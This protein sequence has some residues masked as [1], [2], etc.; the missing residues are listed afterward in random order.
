MSLLH[1]L[2]REEVW[3]D[4]FAYRKDHEQLNRREISELTSFL[5]ER[6]YEHLRDLS[7]S[8]PVKKLISKTRSTK[9]RI[10]YSYMPDEMWVLKLLAYLLYR[11][12]EKLPDSCYAF[13]RKRTVRDALEEIRKIEDLDEKVV[14]KA[15]IHD[16][17]NSIDTAILYEI[18]R[19]VIDDDPELLSF[20]RELLDQDRCIYEGEVITEKRGA[21]A[22]VPLA[23]FFANVYL[24]SL[25]RFF[26]EKGI[27]YFR[28]SDDILFFAKDREEADRY[29]EIL[30]EKIGEKKLTI[31]PEKVTVSGPHE[32]FEFLGIRYEQG[33]YDLS[34]VTVQKMKDRIRRKARSIYR[35]RK[36]NGTT[37]EKAAASLIRSMDH[38][39][40]DLFGEN[41]FT[42]TRWYFPVL[43]STNGLHEIDRT[44]VQYLR[45]LK[46]GRHYKGNYQVSYE[47][48]KKLGYTSLVHEFYTWKKE[49]VKL[50]EQYE[51]QC[52]G[53]G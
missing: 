41:A 39:F 45:F 38:K 32:P 26:E 23:S 46:T 21:M 47:E 24:M 37:Y 49:N 51:K 42:W 14:V 31:N 48:L 15:D 27:P 18:L 44:M 11:Y 35:K 50:R 40:Y 4:F 28:Y 20:L 1:D 10:V 8:Y 19:E 25:D 2:Q 36:R 34:H 6:R 13:R 5:A 30:L 43:T 3:N 12:E 33:Q 52:R 29:Y 16:Y 53:N 17:F 7:F 22:G 9:K